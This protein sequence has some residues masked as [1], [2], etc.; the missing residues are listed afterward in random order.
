MIVKILTY[1]HTLVYIWWC[2]HTL[3]RR[4]SL[5][6]REGFGIH[7]FCGNKM[8]IFHYAGGGVEEV[9]KSWEYTIR[10]RHEHHTLGVHSVS[11]A[12]RA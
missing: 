8:S 2:W 9:A 5:K 12:H 4:W 6:G 7:V 10:K 3:R 1:M 11:T